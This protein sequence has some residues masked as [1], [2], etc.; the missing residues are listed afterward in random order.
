MA[1]INKNHWFVGPKE[2]SISLMRFYVGIE[3][4][5]DDVDVFYRLSVYKDNKVAL[6]F[7][8]YSLEDA[9]RF[10]EDEIDECY[11]IDD[12]VAIY[13]ED[14]PENKFVKLSESDPMEVVD[15]KIVL[16]PE[17]VKQAIWNC[18]GKGRNYKT[19]VDY[20]I[21]MNDGQLAVSFYI[22]EHIGVDISVRLTDG[23]LRYALLKYLE[24]INYELEEADY[25]FDENKSQFGGIK[26]TVKEKA[27][28]LSKTDKRTSK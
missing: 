19:S 3:I 8:F 2:I 20:K 17:Q 18:F 16:T 15:N 26:L 28:R 9:V 1:R 5:K 23:D 22:I 4:M 27:K 21:D 6:V 25:F 24:D 13:K 11:T 14:Y 12:I 7:D 10:T